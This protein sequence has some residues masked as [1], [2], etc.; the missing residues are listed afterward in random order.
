MSAQKLVEREEAEALSWFEKDLEDF[1]IDDATE[2]EHEEQNINGGK[3][4]S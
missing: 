3:T 2:E 1:V 4:I